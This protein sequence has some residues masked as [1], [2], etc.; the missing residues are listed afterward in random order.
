MSIF[1]RQVKDFSSNALPMFIAIMVTGLL[2]IQNSINN[3]VNDILDNIINS[4]EL[5]IVLSRLMWSV[6]QIVPAFGFGLASD[7]HRRIKILMVSHI[8]GITTI[9]LLYWFQSLHWTFLAV[10]FLFNPFSICRA[11]LLDNYPQISAIAI[12]ATTFIARNVFW[13]FLDLFPEGFSSNILLWLVGALIVSLFILYFKTKD[14][15]ENAQIRKKLEAQSKINLIRKNTFP[16]TLSILG[17]VFA[18]TSFYVLWILLESFGHSVESWLKVTTS[19]ALLGALIPVFFLRGK[20]IRDLKNSITTL[21]LI[22]AIVGFV[23]VFLFTQTHVPFQINRIG[24]IS[25]IGGI[26]LSLVSEYLIAAAGSE[27]KAVGSAFS[28]LSDM[29][30]LFLSSLITIFISFIQLNVFIIFIIAFG[31]AALLQFFSE[32]R[33]VCL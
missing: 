33:V 6:I 29:I 14:R 7:H 13:I 16:L 17:L 19:G 3:P 8:L 22:A 11:T 21:Y 31:L 32:K 10:G 1:Y 24:I 12:V 30:A 26:Y 20:A 28:E 27:R 15:Y 5:R 18:E 25:L 9:S 2:D 4:R 23:C